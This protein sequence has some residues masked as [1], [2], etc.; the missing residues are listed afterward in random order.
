MGSPARKDWRTTAPVTW[1]MPAGGGM[2]ALAAAGPMC[3]ITT[4]GGARPR[5]TIQD[6]FTEEAGKACQVT[7][8]GAMWVP[9]GRS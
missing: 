7:S 4:I 5:S 3:G 2:S 8:P 6:G 9:T 1:V